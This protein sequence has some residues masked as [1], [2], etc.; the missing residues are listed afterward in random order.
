MAHLVAGRSTDRDRRHLRHRCP[1]RPGRGTLL[2]AVNLGG[3]ILGGQLDTG[4]GVR[5]AANYLIPFVV[6]SLGLL[7]RS[8]VR[9]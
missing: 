9:R 5:V 3:R 6:S 7:S 8:R 2:T 1:D 4:T